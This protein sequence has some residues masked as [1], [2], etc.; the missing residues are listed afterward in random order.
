ML[1]QS[2]KTIQFVKKF[3]KY[4][5]AKGE[6]EREKAAHYVAD[7]IKQEG[8][9]FLK[10]AQYLGTN[11]KTSKAIQDLS[12]IENNGIELEDIK[13]IISV[14]L[15]QSCSDIF[16]SIDQNA[17]TASVGQVHKAKLISGESVAVKV[18]YPLIEKTLKD[19][20][21][22]LKLIPTGK[23]E[24]K[25]GV[26]IG[27]YQRMI[28]KLLAEELDYSKEMSKQLEVY[29]KIKKSSYIKVP[30]VYKDLSTKKILITEF[31]DGECIRDIDLWSIQEK[32]KLSESIVFSFLELLKNGYLQADTNHGNFIFLKNEK[33]IKV[34]IIDFGQFTSF[35]ERYVKALFSL[36]NNLIAEEEVDYF[37]YLVELGF[38]GEKLK[39]IQKSLPLLSKVIF[40]PFT[41]NSS[42]NLNSWN[43]KKKIELILG[44]DKWW[45]RSAGGEDFF[46]LLKSFM[47]FKNLIQKL[48]GR[49]NW[50]QIF[51]ESIV[52]IKEELKL[53]TPKK[54]FG[55]EAE[56]T[57]F[58]TKLIVNVLENN[59]PKIN[60]VMPIKAI[61]D[62]DE[63]I[64][65]EILVKLIEKNIDINKLV[66]DAL[67]NGAKA[68]TLFSLKD[69]DK[70]YSI[71]I[72]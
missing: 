24:K 15:K 64:D 57:G 3:K 23:A 38:D 27:E 10:V 62:L 39:H 61:F 1:K 17:F 33:Q 65:N 52:D 50:Q 6:I 49:V 53:Y 16:E 26:D 8:G 31:L 32:K 45:F 5:S 41:E 72:E 37:S 58:S 68:Q 20:M 14:E 71:S 25:W 29:N 44:E 47:G 36:I 12:T 4:K 7:F 42:F 28:Q 40:E 22:L 34:G 59:K 63:I 21:K 54:V 18:Q 48:N 13:L 70:Q 30:K 56:F 2:I 19:Q 60:I 43:Y 35:S 66:I 9:L 11:S 55:I 51:L 69:L 46:L 67:K